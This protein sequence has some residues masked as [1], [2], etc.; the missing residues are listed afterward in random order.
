MIEP[1]LKRWL[2]PETIQWRRIQTSAHLGGALSVFGVSGVSV[3]P[4]SFV[5][6]V[7]LVVS[8]LTVCFMILP[9]LRILIYYDCLNI[10]ICVLFGMLV[11]PFSVF[12]VEVVILMPSE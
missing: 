10:L 8:V 12:I 1:Y 3:F 4:A 5:I 2:H 6:P 7:G 9:V 11:L